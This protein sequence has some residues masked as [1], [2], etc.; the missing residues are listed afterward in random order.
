[1]SILHTFEFH[2]PLT[3]QSTVVPNSA[4]D[5]EWSLGSHFDLLISEVRCI[6]LYNLQIFIFQFQRLKAALPKHCFLLAVENTYLASPLKN[7]VFL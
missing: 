7:D 3:N 5:T 4:K 1:M 2:I 6:L